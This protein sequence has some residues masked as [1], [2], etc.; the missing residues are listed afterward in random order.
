MSVYSARRR[1]SH[2]SRRPGRHAPQPAVRPGR[3]AL[4]ADTGAY[5]RVP[6]RRTAIIGVCLLV[7]SGAVG[8]FIAAIS[9]A[10]T[11]A[12]DPAELSL[13]EDPPSAAAPAGAVEPSRSATMTASPLAPHTSAAATVTLDAPMTTPVGPIAPPPATTRGASRAASPTTPGAPTSSAQPTGPD[14]TTAAPTSTDAPCPTCE[15]DGRRPRLE[16]GPQPT[17][18]VVP[19]PPSAGFRSSTAPSW[20][21]STPPGDGLQ[22]ITAVPH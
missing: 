18:T 1:G 13:A 15:D 2:A 17:R 16:G 9:L 21:S 4:D 14:R 20:R 19:T 3:P 11:R 12:D 7:T 6:G 22:L 10:A 8:T 5:E